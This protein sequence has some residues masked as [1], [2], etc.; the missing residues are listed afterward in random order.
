MT[1]REC[2]PGRGC[3]GFTLVEVLVALAIVAVALMAALRAVGTLTDSSSELRSRSLALW[4]AENRLARIRIE[5]EWPSPGRRSS[6]C[7]QA[8]V[9]L[10]CD[11]EVIQTPNPFFRRVEVTVFD[12]A[13]TRRLARLTGFAT[14]VP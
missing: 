1:W 9:V 7:D 5:G 14:S 4:S 8:A 2:V 3:R 12:E 11:E 10:I 13:R 6:P